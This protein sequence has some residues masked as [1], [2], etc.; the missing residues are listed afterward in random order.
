MKQSGMK[1]HVLLTGV[2][3]FVGKVVLWQLMTQREEL[4]IGKVSVLIR[5]KSGSAR[6]GK[7]AAAAKSEAG[8][9]KPAGQS[10]A[11]RFANKVANSEIFR[12][13][14]EGWRDLVQ[15]VNADLEQPDLGMAP[16]DRHSLQTSVTHILHCA[17]SVEFDL[18]IASA[19]GANVEAALHML[20]LARGCSKL[21]AMV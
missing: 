14:P 6:G 4:G 12:S 9:K 13:L 17:A 1:R 11:E 2:T 19:L 10:P 15:V 21:V 5:S 20:E 3:G 7:K 18:P 16:S 8:A